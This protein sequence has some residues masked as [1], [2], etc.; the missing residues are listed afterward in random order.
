MII[1]RYDK[2]TSEER[3]PTM[4]L[5]GEIE[6]RLKIFFTK[7]YSNKKN[8]SHIAMINQMNHVLFATSGN[9]ENKRILDLGCGSN[10]PHLEGKGIFNDRMFEPWLCRGLLELGAIP[11]GIDIGDLSKE[12]FEHYQ[13]NLLGLNCLNFIP[14]SSIDITNAH[15]LFN[16]PHLNQSYMGLNSSGREL[17][18]ILLPQLKRIVKPKGYFI[19]SDDYS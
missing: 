11:I 16:S 5:A 19:Y 8:E 4:N 9:L 3:Y 14:N 7:E 13:L 6:K 15:E 12:K 1:K 2:I 17:K 18:E 10:D